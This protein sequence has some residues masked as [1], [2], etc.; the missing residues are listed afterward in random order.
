MLKP[1]LKGK[2]KGK[3]EEEKEEEEARLANSQ[4]PR[5]ML[6]RVQQR[7]MP[8][9]LS[10]G[11]N[12]VVPRVQMARL[13]ADALRRRRVDGRL[14][15]RDLQRAGAGQHRGDVVE[16]NVLAV[17]LVVDV[18]PQPAHQRILGRVVLHERDVHKRQAREDEGIRLGLLAAK[19][20]L[21]RAVALLHDA[22][23]KGT[24]DAVL[25]LTTPGL[26]HK[27][28]VRG[29]VVDVVVGEQ[30]GLGLVGRVGPELLV[31]AVGAREAVADVDAV[32]GGVV[33]RGRVLEVVPDDDDL[34]EGGDVI[35]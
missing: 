35:L 9:P 31:E 23:C 8:K 4:P 27:V 22:P 28:E 18:P 17:E 25:P 34:V 29:L 16:R 3:I 13:G 2:Y 21:P 26:E 14:E 19:V 11:V 5:S 12:T 1:N 24:R 33:G 6:R 32:G 20:V 10:K 7:H 30:D 15:A